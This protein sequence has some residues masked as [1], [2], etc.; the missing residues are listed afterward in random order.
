MKIKVEYESA[1]NNNLEMVCKYAGNYA[2]NEAVCK[3]IHVLTKTSTIDRE[4]WVAEWKRNYKSGVSAGVGYV[5]S[6]C[7]MWNERSSLFCPSCGRAMSDEAL[8]KLE[9]R[10]MVAR[11]EV[12]D[13]TTALMTN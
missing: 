7:D 13:V 3:D 9:K 5:C 12:E 6:K 2:E 8:D 10:L 4:A 1:C 11:N